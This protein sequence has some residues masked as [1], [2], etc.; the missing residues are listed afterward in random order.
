MGFAWRD[1]QHV[2]MALKHSSQTL[3]VSMGGMF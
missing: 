2:H 3:H 1:M